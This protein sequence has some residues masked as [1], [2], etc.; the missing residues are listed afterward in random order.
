MVRALVRAHLKTNAKHM[1]PAISHQGPGTALITGAS[2]GIG[3]ELSKVFAREGY[4]LVLVARNQQRL[5]EVAAELRAA[6]GGDVHALA[7]D[8]GLASTPSEILSE[9]QQQ[10]LALDLLV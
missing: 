5:Q 6:H 4:R 9:S 2:T 7:K 3:Y 8:L 10:V 1:D